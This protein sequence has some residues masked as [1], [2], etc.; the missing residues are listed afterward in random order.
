MESRISVLCW[1]VLVCIFYKGCPISGQNLANTRARLLLPECNTYCPVNRRCV[2]DNATVVWELNPP[3]ECK[4]YLECYGT[5]SKYPNDKAPN[6]I[7][8]GRLYPI[9]VALGSNMYFKAGTFGSILGPF[10]VYNVTKPMFLTC[11]NATQVVGTLTSTV[12]VP[13]SFVS[14]VGYKFFI[15]KGRGNYLPCSFGMRLHVNVIGSTG[16]SGTSRSESLC[17]GKGRC[18]AESFTGDIHCE[19][20]VGYKGKYCEELDACSVD[21]CKRGNCS[22]VI[23]GHDEVFNCTCEAGFAGQ[24]CDIDINE[25]DLPE[26][27]GVCK[28]GA[29]CTDAQNS[30][31]CLCQPGF[32]GKQCEFL[33]NL[34]DSIRPCKNNA[35]CSRVGARKESYVC[36]CAAGFYGRNCTLNSTTSSL[37]PQ[38]STIS[39]TSSYKVSSMSLST[40]SFNTL[41]TFYSSIKTNELSAATSE[42]LAATVFSTPLASTSV[43]TSA[44]WMSE[45]VSSSSMNRLSDISSV[46]QVSTTNIEETKS[47]DM[48]VSQ[49]RTLSDVSSVESFISTKLNVV[50]STLSPTTK[51]MQSIAPS[52]STLIDVQSVT[53]MMSPSSTHQLEPSQ[54]TSK[55]S[56]FY[57]SSLKTSNVVPMT[58]NLQQTTI[59]LSS[60]TQNPSAIVSLSASYQLSSPSK[61]TVTIATRLSTYSSSASI[62]TPVILSTPLGSTHTLPPLP[63][64]VT[65]PSVTMAMPSSIVVPPTLPPLENQTCA[66][67]PCGEHGSCRNRASVVAGLSFHCDCRYPTVGPVC[68]TG[69]G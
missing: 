16:C 14:S 53:D 35:N 10:T 4:T 61:Q 68:T 66:D 12:K 30:Y 49:T 65:S 17:S 18:I 33:S 58:T 40:A 50:D 22:D 51:Y 20:C 60:P 7:F 37:I 38:L 11:N 19:C 36:H 3:D 48:I 64:S 13:D 6:A 34:C 21:P 54:S 42:K 55:T 57:Q 59:D 2:Q 1:C 52:I 8:A 41:S 39:K 27:Q 45:M 28:N 15:A 67:N 56:S 26:N 46:Y 47:M 5:N 29:L 25:C 31:V 9:I 62:P 63:S 43:E 24:L 23:A 32:H 69:I 44:G